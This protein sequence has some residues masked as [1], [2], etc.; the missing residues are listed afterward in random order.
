MCG[1]FYSASYRNEYNWPVL[2]NF[3]PLSP[4]GAILGIQ[5]RKKRFLALLDCAS[6]G[7][8][9]GVW[10]PSCVC[11]I[12]YLRSYCMDFFQILVFA[13]RSTYAQTFF[14]LNRFNFFTNIFRFR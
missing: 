2:C 10:R 9:M 14:F 1:L 13:S 8:G 11:G 3:P 6:R 5:V 4:P 12:D 7:H